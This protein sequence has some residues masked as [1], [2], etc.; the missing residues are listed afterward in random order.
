[1]QPETPAA[2]VAP[3]DLVVHTRSGYRGGV[4]DVDPIFSGTE[5]WYEEGARSRPPKDAPWYHV[6]VHDAEHATYAAE[7]HLLA[8]PEPRPIDHPL[9]GHFFD[10]FRDGRYGQDR[11]LN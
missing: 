6:L 11:P 5:Q 4:V 7:R 10:H 2:R 1:M 3:G 9:L 8:E